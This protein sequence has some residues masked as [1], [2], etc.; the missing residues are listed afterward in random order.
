MNTAILGLAHHLPPETEVVGVRRPIAAEPTGAS[1]LAMDPVRRALE[2]A[3]VGVEDVDF[4]IFATMTPDVVFPGAACF[5]HHQLDCQTTGALDIRAQCS[6]FPFGLMVADGFLRTGMYRRILLVMSEIHSPGLD[7]SEQGARVAALYGDGA[8]AAILGKNE[9]PGGL[10]AIACHTDGRLYDRFW[11]E[12]P[13]SR[14]KP[15]MRVEDFHAGR[16]FPALDF[17][18]VAE[19]GREHLPAVV[20]EVLEKASAAVDTVDWFFL[21]HILPGVVEDSA[22]GV[23]IPPSKLIDAGERHGHL[24]AATLPLALS[25][26]VSEG[27]VG[28]GDRV[29]LATCGAGF[30]WGA[31]LMTL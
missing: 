29:C 8:V 17:D 6:G 3:G 16:H 1:T 24:T 22:A 10:Q 23:G 11:C 31:A 2:Q 26:A 28:R 19:F 13:S 20:R 15:R 18:R 12:Y 25:E 14:R 5:L 21:S 7:Y 30:T 4:I 9:G 27:K